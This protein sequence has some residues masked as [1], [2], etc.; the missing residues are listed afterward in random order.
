MSNIL[1]QPYLFFDGNCAEATEFYRT[2]LG[3]EVG[4]TMLYKECPD[5]L[6]PE[7]LTPAYENKVMHTSFRIGDTTI[8]ASDGGGCGETP[9]AFGGF[10]LSLSVPTE[11]E[12]GR[13]FN[14]L[15]GGGTVEMPLGK[16]FWSPCFGMVKDRFGV[17][18]MVTVPEPMADA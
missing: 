5:P 8:M 1:V 14:A 12:A 7:M 13:V 4:Q 16:T 9:L 2:A 17:G 10:S 3:A 6:P 18:W 15:A 11:E